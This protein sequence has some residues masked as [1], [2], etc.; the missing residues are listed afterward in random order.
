MRNESQGKRLSGLPFRILQRMSGRQFKEG[1]DGDIRE[2]YEKVLLERGKIRASCWIWFNTIFSVPKYMMNGMVW[3][4]MMLKNYVK[5]ASRNIVN[6]KV[7]SAINILGLAMGL[8]IFT[9]LSII[10]GFNTHAD[11]F[12]ENADRIFSVVQVLPSVQEGEVHTA[13]TPYPL[14]S[15]LKNDFP[16]I[17][18]GTRILPAGRMIIGEGEKKFYEDRILFAGPDFLSIFSFDLSE[19]DPSTALSEPLSII[20]SEAMA[21]KYFGDQNPI[22]RTLILENEITVTV[23]GILNFIDDNYSSIYFEF[24]VSLETARHLPN[25]QDDWETHR[26]GTLLLLHKNTNP[27]P[28]EKKLQSVLDQSYPSSPEAPVKLSLLSLLDFRLHS[29]HIASFWHSTESFLNFSLTI[30]GLLILSIVSI[31]FINLSTARYMLRIKEVGLRKVVGAHRSQLAKQFLS[32]SIL[33]ALLALPLSLLMYDMMLRTLLRILIQYQGQITV[34]NHPFITRY[35]GATAV[36]VGIVAGSYPAFFLSSFRPVKILKGEIRHGKRGSRLRRLLVISQFTVTALLIV[37]TLSWKELHE[38]FF[39]ADMGYNRQSILTIKLT[40][41]TSGHT[42]QF[43]E[44]LRQNSAIRSVSGAAD[45]PIG[46]SNESYAVPEASDETEAFKTDLYDVDYG[47]TRTLDIHV[48]K[49]QALTRGQHHSGHI[50]INDLLAERLGWSE[51]IGKQLEVEGELKTVV[52]V[53]E[54]FHFK[55]V[56]L[57]RGPAILRL[58]PTRNRFLLVKMTSSGEETRIMSEVEAQWRRIVPDK[59]FEA[60][61]LDNHFFDD[62]RGDRTFLYIFAFIDGIAILVSCLGLLGMAAYAVQRK[63]KEIGIRKT[64]GASITSIVRLL[65][66]EFFLLVII[67]DTI[68]MTL[69]YFICNRLFQYRLPDFRIPIGAHVFIWTAFITVA[70]AVLAVVFQTVKAAQT[71]PVETLRYE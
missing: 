1:Y 67:A 48:Q 20:L 10:V 70:T 29:E 7:Y 68:G 69:G 31:N 15:T 53:T 6:Q 66:R 24:L 12:H 44:I 13:F 65:V 57:P 3:G 17:E 8:S 54:Y 27:L 62:F 9:L 52:G 36:L 32:E 59:P 56:N 43:K 26:F 55:S 38:Y 42:E 23:T 5:V 18:K 16:E 63:T 35:L 46:W 64:L 50:L 2:E 39:I 14:F 33:M 34:W 19:G 49:G 58:D 45:L 61:T 47:F 60:Y 4:C 41:T 30:V 37:I 11:R 21:E 22:G 71:N 25:W 40:E 28:L 51:P